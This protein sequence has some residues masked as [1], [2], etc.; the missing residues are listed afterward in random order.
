MHDVMLS[1]VLRILLF[2]TGINS[3]SESCCLAS[4]LWAW[5]KQ[6]SFGMSEP[7]ISAHLLIVCRNGHTVAALFGTESKDH[8]VY[9]YD[10]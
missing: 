1:V 5:H 2:H 3:G 9:F 10:G 8:S 6:L 4:L 7:E